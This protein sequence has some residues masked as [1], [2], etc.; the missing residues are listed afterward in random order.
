MPGKGLAMEQRP[1]RGD[2]A[3][4]LRGNFACA[5]YGRAG[6]NGG[7]AIAPHNLPI[8]WIRYFESYHLR[9]CTEIVCTQG[10]VPTASP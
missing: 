9:D 8:T 4:I 3:S 7:K 1:E 10:S 2:L 6:Y 5:C